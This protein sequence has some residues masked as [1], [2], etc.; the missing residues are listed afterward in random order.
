MP[1]EKCLVVIADTV[2]ETREL[3]GEICRTEFGAYV[4][5][6]R[7]AHRVLKSVSEFTPNLIIVEVNQ[8]AD[9]ETV[10]LLAARRDQS[11]I[12]ILALTAWGPNTP[13][14]CERIL[15]SGAHVC[16]EKPFGLDEVIGHAE[17]LLGRRCGPGQ[18]A[19]PAGE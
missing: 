9:L 3:L 16:I 6:H 18:S 1:S 2:E 7:E 12:P 15:A 19:N 10:Q 8:P 11:P 5:S 17:T 4:T 14:S 13:L